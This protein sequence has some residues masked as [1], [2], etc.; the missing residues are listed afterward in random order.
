MRP[1]Y[2]LITGRTT[3]QADGLH[4]GR[5]SEVYIR[6][7]AVVE[8]SPQEM[9]RLGVEE[10]Q[11]VRVSTAAGRVE[12]RVQAGSLPAGMLFMPMGPTANVLISSDTT[13]TGMPAFKGVTAEVEAI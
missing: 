8:M 2:T 13:A 9:A 4:Q 11:L 1:Q 5:D 12:V 3:E 7:T 6:A 10:G